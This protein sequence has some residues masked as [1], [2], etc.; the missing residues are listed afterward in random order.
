MVRRFC[1]T[2]KVF[3]PLVAMVNHIICVPLIRLSGLLN[4]T[5]HTC[6]EFDI[7]DF[8]LPAFRFELTAFKP[9]SETAPRRWVALYL[10]NQISQ[11]N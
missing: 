3:F 5:L 6:S 1:V 2:N 7:T 11:L 10:T 9:L 8:G 4:P